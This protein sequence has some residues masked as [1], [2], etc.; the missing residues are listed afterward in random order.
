MDPDRL[1][2]ARIVSVRMLEG[3][4]VDNELMKGHT[5]RVR[6]LRGE[7]V[8]VAHPASGRAGHVWMRRCIDHLQPDSTARASSLRSSR[9]VAWARP[10]PTGCPN[11]KTIA[12]RGAV[13]LVWSQRA[14][15]Q[16]D[17]AST[18]ASA[19]PQGLRVWRGAGEDYRSE[20]LASWSSIRFLTSRC[21][22]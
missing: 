17:R 16:T 11:R 6:V 9:R 5:A 19:T 1:D 15:K 4:A 14:G 18:H 21:S 12:Q 22:P 7:Q 10:D 8:A 2:S 13:Q 20:A 3:L